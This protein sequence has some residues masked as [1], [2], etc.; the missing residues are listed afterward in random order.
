MGQQIFGERLAARRDAALGSNTS[1]QRAHPCNVQQLNV[2]RG[3][4]HPSGR[5]IFL[6]G[7]INT[8]LTAV[9]GIGAVVVVGAL[10]KGLYFFVRARRGAIPR[11]VVAD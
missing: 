4:L 11:P 8:M 3:A 1:V 9:L 7:P 2:T 6:Q 10:A 5:L